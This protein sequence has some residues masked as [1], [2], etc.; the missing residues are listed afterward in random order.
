M[1]SKR[2]KSKEFE[3]LKEDEIKDIENKY[4]EIFIEE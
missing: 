1:L 4:L 3:A 2:A